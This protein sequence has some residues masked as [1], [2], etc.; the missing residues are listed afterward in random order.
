MSTPPKSTMEAAPDG[1]MEGVGT[2]GRLG[3]CITNNYSQ[4]LMLLLK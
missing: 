2:A 3:Y 4:V 1:P